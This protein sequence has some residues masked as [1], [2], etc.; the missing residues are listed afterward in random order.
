MTE[1][2]NTA[3]IRAQCDNHG[4]YSAVILDLCDAVDA[5]RVELDNARADF[6]L[7][8]EQRNDLTFILEAAEQKRDN[9]GVLWRAAE[10]EQNQAIARAEAAEADLRLSQ[11][12]E[13][14]RSEQADAAEAEVERALTHPR[15]VNLRIAEALN[16][17]NASQGM[18]ET[19]G[20]DYPCLTRRALTKET[21]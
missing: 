5:A 18:C 13:Q 15:G 19:C 3:A 17:H 11:A 2:P 7:A 20:T 16:L 21:P 4:W 6:L 14:N 12:A 8:R 1:H 10:D 9:Y